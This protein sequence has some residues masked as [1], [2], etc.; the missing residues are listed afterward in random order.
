[1][2]RDVAL[3]PRSIYMPQKFGLI[4]R[5]ASLCEFESVVNLR[6]HFF[7]N[8]VQRFQGKHTRQSLDLIRLLPWPEFVE[9]S[10]A[11]VVVL[12]RSDV[13]APSIGQTF[14]EPRPGSFANGLDSTKSS[15]TNREDVLIFDSA[16]RDPVGRHAL[17]K[18]RRCPSL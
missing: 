3:C 8:S 4:G 10:I 17:A 12:A 14:N 7:R 2:T 11:R 5:G 15:F 16:S 6:C 18:T 9:A 1:M 13:P